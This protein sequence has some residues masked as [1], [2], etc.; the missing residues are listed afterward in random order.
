MEIDTLVS[1]RWRIRTQRQD[2]NSP[3]SGHGGLAELLH[4][5]AR[6][7]DQRILAMLVDGVTVCDLEDYSGGFLLDMVE[8]V[9]RRLHDL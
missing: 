9:L 6:K 2:V 7:V 5:S 3:L 8:E 4:C 1:R